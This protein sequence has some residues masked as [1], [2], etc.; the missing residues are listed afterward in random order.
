MQRSDR[1]PLS[2]MVGVSLAQKALYMLAVNPKLKGLLFSAKVG[3]GKS[4]LMDAFA[5]FF[6]YEKPTYGLPINIDINN[7]IGGLDFEQTLQQSKQVFKEGLLSQAHQGVLICDSLNLLS[8][9]AA[10]IVL[11]ALDN[12]YLDI[13]ST[14]MSARVP[15]EF[16][17]L[18]AYNPDE[19]TPRKHLLERIGM[20]VHLKENTS[21]KLRQSVLQNNLSQ[22]SQQ[23]QEWQE[24]D[25]IMVRLIA[26]ARDILPKVKARHSQIKKI[27]EMAQYCRVE[28]SR[29]ELFA[30]EAA[31]A[32]AALCLREQIEDEDIETALKLSIFPRAQ[33]SEEALMQLLMEQEQAANEK[34][35]EAS[36]QDQFDNS[37]ETM[38]STAEQID[39]KEDAL[40]APEELSGNEH[41][42]ISAPPSTEQLDDVI[43]DTEEVVLPEEIVNLSAFKPSRGNSRVGSHG[44]TASTRGHHVRSVQGEPTV[45]PIDIIATL[46]SAAPWQN[47]RK[48]EPG[49]FTI[50]KEDLH[51]KEFSA[52]AG[53]LYI[54]LVDS[55]GSMAV[56]RMRQAKGTVINL[57]EHAYINRDQVA[58]ISCRGQMAEILLEPTPSV[59]LAKRKL[60]VLPTG[61]AT[62]LSSALQLVFDVI[63]SAKHIRIHNF[64]LVLMTDGKFNV[65]LH[66]QQK[67]KIIEEVQLLCRSLVSSGV[68]SIVVNTRKMF[69]KKQPA[70][71]L[72]EWLEASYFDLG[73]KKDTQLADK[74]KQMVK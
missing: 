73:S 23:Q 37:P 49:H 41:D 65:G 44:Q 27:A 30:L 26:Q 20:Q 38:P 8:D 1:L 60:D 46:R 16:I 32:L 34:M 70:N 4:S 11:N 3:S 45:S 6:S 13:A 63:R 59:E 53:T 51:I 57:L 43:F 2:A 55:S 74:I 72:S 15:T 67:E 7:L 71:Q 39:A 25:Q 64:V 66:S 22:D 56:N 19:G 17:F 33:I 50:L 40:N 5:H 14:G 12:G 58:L 29:G 24:E 35:Q 48:K 54:F 10:N 18:G 52:K 62:P 69:L 31:R 68:Q 47:I 36:N 21:S 28:G 42:D 61:N 9:E